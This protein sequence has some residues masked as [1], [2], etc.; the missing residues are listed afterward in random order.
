LGLSFLEIIVDSNLENTCPITF[1]SRE[2]MINLVDGRKKESRL[3]G[4]SSFEK[5]E[6]N[7]DS[8]GNLKS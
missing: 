3:D 4:C 2:I 1:L 7:R 8:V 6:V 5:M